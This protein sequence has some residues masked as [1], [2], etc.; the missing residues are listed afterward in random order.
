MNKP[1][2]TAIIVA[3]G[4]GTR[5]KAGVNKQYLLLQGKPILAHTIQVFE[6]CELIHEVIVVVGK[7]EKL[8]CLQ[9]IIRPYGYE[10]VKRIVIG[11]DTRQQSMYNGLKAVTPHTDIVIT[12]DGARPLIHQEILKKSIQETQIHKATIVGVPVKDTIK[13]INENG[14]VHTTPKRDLVWIVQTPQ[15]FSYGLIIEAHERA[16]K[17]SFIG[18]D[19]AT[20]VERIGHPI[21][22]IKGEYDNIKI[23]TPED[24]IMAEAIL[25][26]QR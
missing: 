5:M 8:K 16:Y 25:N 22:I 1:Y 2:V 20:L 7:N 15:S 12:H 3:A 9:E 10:K 14:F 26:I 4:Q 17:E 19:D 23:T 24:L 18:T 6:R 13:M 11:G 21:K